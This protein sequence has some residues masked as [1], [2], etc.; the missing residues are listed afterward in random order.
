[1]NTKNYDLILEHRV[2]K[3]QFFPISQSICIFD[4]KN[5]KEI[6]KIIKN[7]SG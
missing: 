7:K 6:L 3:S 2:K 1:M 4:K 5:T